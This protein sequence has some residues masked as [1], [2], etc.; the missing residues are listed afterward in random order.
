MGFCSQGVGFGTEGMGF[1]SKGMG[2][3]SKGMSVCS[4]GLRFC[5]K[6]H[7]SFSKGPFACGKGIDYC[8]EETGFCSTEMDSFS[9]DCA[10]VRWASIVEG[11]LLWES[12]VYAVACN[13]KPSHLTIWAALLSEMSVNET[14][15]EGCSAK[16]SKP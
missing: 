13:A 2:S 9:E 14:V 4:K 8:T 16:L 6:G 1:C 12:K 7:A 10:G 15:L 5:S 11:C 3:C